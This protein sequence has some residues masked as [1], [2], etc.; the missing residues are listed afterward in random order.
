M[1]LLIMSKLE[2]ARKTLWSSSLSTSWHSTGESV[3]SSSTSPTASHPA[4]LGTKHLHEDL[5]IDLHASTTT[6]SSPAECVHRV[7]QVL[8]TIV[9]CTFPKFALAKWF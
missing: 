1:L 2:A 9:A 7:H 6:H 4:H 8:A 5:G 3:E